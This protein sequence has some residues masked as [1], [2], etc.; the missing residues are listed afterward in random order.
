MYIYPCA[1]PLLNK[2]VTYLYLLTYLLTNVLSMHNNISI[3][4]SQREYNAPLLC[5]CITIHWVQEEWPL[6]QVGSYLS[7][8]NG[9]RL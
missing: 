5:L 7:R 9:P 8:D 3:L 6:A 2:D 4:L 1:V